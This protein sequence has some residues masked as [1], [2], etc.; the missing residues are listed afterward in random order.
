MEFWVVYIEDEKGKLRV[1]SKSPFTSLYEA[2]KYAKPI[3]PSRNAKVL[4]EA[5]QGVGL[6]LVTEHA[7]AHRRELQEERDSER[8]SKEFRKKHGWPPRGLPRRKKADADTNLT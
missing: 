2:Q 6:D 8:R 3:D 1:S 5:T 7:E 4:V